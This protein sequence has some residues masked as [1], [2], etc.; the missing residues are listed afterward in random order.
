[1]HRKQEQYP[2]KLFSTYLVLLQHYEP[3][4]KIQKTCTT[5]V[6]NKQN[7]VAMTPGSYNIAKESKLASV[8]LIS[9]KYSA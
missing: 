1:M 6:D 5:S 3:N 8:K 4:V 7:D 9:F 2:K